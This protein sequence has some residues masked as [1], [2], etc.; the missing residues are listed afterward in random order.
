[1]KVLSRLK[2]RKPKNPKKPHRIRSSV[3]MDNKKLLDIISE[4]N[5]E[6]AE[7]KELIECM[8]LALLSSKNLFILGDT[9]QGKSYAINA[10]RKLKVSFP[11]HK[12]NWASV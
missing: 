4:I 3:K 12:K 11:I 5:D 10:F 8:V 7:R 9:G 2:R 6:I 1:M